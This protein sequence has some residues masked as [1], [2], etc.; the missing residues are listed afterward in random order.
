MPATNTNTAIRQQTATR[1][2]KPFPWATWL[3]WLITVTILLTL[4]GCLLTRVSVVK[5][6]FCEFDSNFTLSMDG[7]ME[8]L[9]HDPVLLD[10]D[11]LW[12]SASEPSEIIREG[13]FMAMNWVIEKVRPVP[14]P[15][16]DVEIR[17]NF[18]R[19][20]DRFKL[21]QV[22]FDE[23][24]SAV[25]GAG[26]ID[27]ELMETAINNVCNAGL[28][29]ASTRMKMEISER[30]IERLPSREEMFEQF[31]DP[32]ETIE[33]GQVYAY[34]YRVKPNPDMPQQ[35]P[36]KTARVLVWFDPDG[37]KPIRMESHY[38]RYRTEA[39]F[40]NRE[41]LLKVEI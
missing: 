8:F 24:L 40:L 32:T 23:K 6:Q 26:S 29:L 30:D 31:G 39:D 10:S 9:F 18:I 16:S 27:P 1:A 22:R 7:G 4:S 5:N 19:N 41:W 33:P 14:D 13:D 21:A 17:L 36:G 25:T 28:S 15:A 35:K 12:L 2:T 34:E 11:I 38:S 20:E 3:K 37:E